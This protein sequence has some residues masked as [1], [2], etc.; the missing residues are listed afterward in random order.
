MLLYATGGAA[1]A[2]LHHWGIDAYEGGCP[3]CVPVSFS[4][5]NAGWVVGAGA[6]WIV[7]RNWMFR[8]EY[9]H[10]EFDSG[11]STGAFVG[12][13]LTGAR[14]NFG[15]TDIDS[16]RAALSYKFY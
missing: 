13:T 9:L 7:A 3:N 11:S 6:E 2:D 14:Y 8:V 15:T 5:S 16:V 1:W 12:T 4:D 10:Y